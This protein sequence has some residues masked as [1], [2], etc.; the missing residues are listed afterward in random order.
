MTFIIFE[1][2]ILSETYFY[3]KA[4]Y[5]NLHFDLKGNMSLALSSLLKLCIR[6][7]EYYII[8]HIIQ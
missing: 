6:D 4:F 7:H 2:V 1:K 5:V 8:L 3:L